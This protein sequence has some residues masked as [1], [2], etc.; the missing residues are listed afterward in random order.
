MTGAIEKQSTSMAGRLAARSKAL[1]TVLFG[2]SQNQTERPH[3]HF[4]GSYERGE[5]LYHSFRHR[6]VPSRAFGLATWDEYK[7][8]IPPEIFPSHVKDLPRRIPESSMI[9]ITSRCGLPSFFC[10]FGL[11]HCAPARKLR[12]S[13][14]VPAWLN[15][16]LIET[17]IIAMRSPK[18]C[19]SISRTGK[20]AGMVRLLGFRHG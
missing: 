19:V 20:L 7:T 11:A 18:S 10:R 8:A 5:N 17:R 4:G 1:A 3:L 9:V 13:N 2:P 12:D 14:A 16:C 6:N 15:L